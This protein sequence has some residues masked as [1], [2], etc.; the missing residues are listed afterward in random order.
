MANLTSINVMRDTDGIR[1][2]IQ[3]WVDGKWKDLLPEVPLSH[4][5]ARD[6]AGLLAGLYAERSGPQ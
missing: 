1:L 6:L 2:H 3:E 5:T 4:G